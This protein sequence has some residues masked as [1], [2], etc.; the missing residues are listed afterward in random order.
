MICRIGTHH[1]VMDLIIAQLNVILED[2]VP[3]PN[4]SASPRLRHHFDSPFLQLDL[5]GVGT[6]LR[7][8]EFLE[9]S[10]CIRG[11]TLDADCK[12]ESEDERLQ[13][14]R[15]GWAVE[16]NVPFRPRRSLAIT[17]IIGAK[18]CCCGGGG[19]GGLG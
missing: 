14:G 19:G 13:C 17:S 1:P 12:S 11:R 2:R 4:R 9:I 8:D 3:E 16:W 5:T 10:D 6:R 7:G 18:Y 15:E